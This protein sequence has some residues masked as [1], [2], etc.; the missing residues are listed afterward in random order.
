M[1]TFPFQSNLQDTSPAENSPVHFS[2]RCVA[3]RMYNET[4]LAQRG[5]VAKVDDGQ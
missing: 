3:F 1:P 5:V 2:T 4:A